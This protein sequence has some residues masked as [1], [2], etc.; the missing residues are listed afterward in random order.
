MRILPYFFLILCLLSPTLQAD[1]QQNQSI[2]PTI[3]VQSKASI[4]AKIDYITLD[5]N[6]RKEAKTTRQAKQVVDSAAKALFGIFKRYAINAEDQD[7]GQIQSQKLYRWNN[8]LNRNEERGQ[9]VSRNIQVKLR[10]LNQL[11]K[12]T[13]EIIQIKH[14]HIQG[15]TFG[16]EQ[17][18][19]LK[20][21]ALQKAVKQA[22]IKADL[23][24]RPLGQSLGKA[25]LIEELD[26]NIPM[27]IAYASKLRKSESFQSSP[28]P[29]PVAKQEISA[30]VHVIFNLAD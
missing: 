1:S 10:Q 21:K 24:L 12:F 19:T 13:H 4:V 23:M 8:Q 16:F 11:A 3:S 18:A 29:M 2:T 28:A 27:P 6:I 22:Q 7:A 15:Q 5:L 20:N 9:I 25:I 30:R 14:V 26:G 17:L